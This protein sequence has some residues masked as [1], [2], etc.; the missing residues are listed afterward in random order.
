MQKI[1]SVQVYTYIASLIS[2]DYDI[3]LSSF[4]NIQQASNNYKQHERMQI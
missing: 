1:T 2:T 3:P 4:E